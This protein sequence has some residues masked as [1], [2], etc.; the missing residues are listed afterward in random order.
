MMIRSIILVILLQHCFDSTLGFSLFDSWKAPFATAVDRKRVDELK[1]LLLT[2]CEIGDR[3]MVEKVIA[4]LVPFSAVSNPSTS[5]AL[6]KKWLLLWTTEKEIN[7]FS[8]WNLSGDITQTIDGAVLQNCIPFQSGGY[9]SVEGSL[10]PSGE[11]RTFFPI[12]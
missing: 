10:E 8:D 3:E 7:L 6:Q 9:L 11:T 5:A 12:Y 4:D 1:D 2:K